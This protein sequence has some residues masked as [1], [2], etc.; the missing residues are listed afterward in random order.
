M[1]DLIAES[2]RDDDQLPWL[3]DAYRSS[4][5]AHRGCPAD[6][7]GGLPVQPYGPRKGAVCKTV[8]CQQVTFGR[9]GC[10]LLPNP[11]VVLDQGGSAALRRA[12][13]RSHPGCGP[14]GRPVAA[15]RATIS[16]ASAA[17]RRQRWLRTRPP[18]SGSSGDGNV[19][20]PKLE[21]AS[22]LAGLFS[23]DVRLW[24]LAPRLRD[25]EHWSQGSAEA[26]RMAIA[27][28][29]GRGEDA[30]SIEGNSFISPTH[31]GGA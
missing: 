18:G 14:G 28:P 3:T 15:R 24:R 23:Q 7:L 4:S 19:G 16:T 21:I 5:S 17:A 9:S 25:A 2:V 22:E 6:R 29:L 11:A 13:P 30:E 20:G 8:G 12:R 27:P 31:T 1:G 26:H 10:E